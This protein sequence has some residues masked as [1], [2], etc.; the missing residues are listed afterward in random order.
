ML[1]SSVFR[2]IVKLFDSVELIV[3]YYNLVFFLY[4]IAA[5]FEVTSSSRK[6]F[7]RILIARK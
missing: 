7:K 5:N 6:V 2:Y 3:K 4:K 1:I